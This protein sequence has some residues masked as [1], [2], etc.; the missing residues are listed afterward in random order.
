MVKVI[1]DFATPRNS[2]FFVG[3]KESHKVFKSIQSDDDDVDKSDYNKLY[4]VK[5]F[6]GKYLQS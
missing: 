2:S 4:L 1:L 3:M 5:V 6:L